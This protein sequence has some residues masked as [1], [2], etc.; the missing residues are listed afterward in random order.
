MDV[1]AFLKDRTGFIRWYY[2]TAGVP[3]REIMRKIETGEAPYE[4]PYSEDP[5]PPFLRRTLSPNRN[6]HTR[7]QRKQ[8]PFV[9][10]S[11]LAERLRFR[12]TNGIRRKPAECGEP[13]R[14]FE[15][16]SKNQ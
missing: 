16:P 12:F 1:L 10:K 9:Q 15:S 8:A 4:P 13:N 11:P 14:E 3:F 7:L 5:E 6:R 2:D